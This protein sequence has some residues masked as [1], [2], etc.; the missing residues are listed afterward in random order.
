[1]GLDVRGPYGV[2]YRPLAGKWEMSLDARIN[3]FMT[4]AKSA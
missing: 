2:T 3:Y 1:M 4:A